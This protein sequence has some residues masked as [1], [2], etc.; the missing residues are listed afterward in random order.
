MI[1]YAINVF[2][3]FTFFATRDERALVDERRHEPLWIRRLMVNGVGCVF[4]AATLMLTV[5]LKFHEGSW[6]TVAITSGVIAL[7]YFVRRH[8]RAVNKAVEQLE[9]DVLP[10]IFC[11]FRQATG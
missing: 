10:E 6:V 7:C 11:G 4:T 9:A 1:L 8:Y 2:V 5:T 3:T